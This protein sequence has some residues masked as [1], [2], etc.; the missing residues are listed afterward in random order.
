[1]LDR[2]K[3]SFCTPE[4]TQM[5][6]RST[7]VGPNAWSALGILFL[8][9]GSYSGVFS[10]GACRPKCI[11]DAGSIAF[12][13]RK[14]LGCAL[15]RRLSAQMRFRCAQ[16][17][18]RSTPVDPN[19]FPMCSDAL[20]K[21]FK[22]AHV[23]LE[24]KKSIRLLKKRSFSAYESFRWDDMENITK[25]NIRFPWDDMENTTKTHVSRGLTLNTLQNHTYSVG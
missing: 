14:A 16:M 7:P 21:G 19:A 5:C 24:R 2:V 18:S 22:S 13:E 3:L 10:L 6:S 25:Q 9:S 15:A 8:S 1:M 12:V 4:A 11:V 17:C 20:S 23:L